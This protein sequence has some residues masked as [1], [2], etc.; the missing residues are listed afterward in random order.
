[1]GASLQLAERPS[2]VERVIEIIREHFANGACDLRIIVSDVP[3]DVYDAVEGR[4]IRRWPSGW[5]KVER[6]AVGLSVEWIARP[7][8]RAA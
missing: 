4:L 8:E 7:E 6:L 1:M 3:A 2:A 5:I